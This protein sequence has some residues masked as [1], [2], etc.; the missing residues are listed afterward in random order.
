MAQDLK[1]VSI[2][3][4]TNKI[5]QVERNEKCD[6]EYNRVFYSKS[7]NSSRFQILVAENWYEND[8]DF[9]IVYGKD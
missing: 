5:G 6:S 8:C 1:V 3:K 7:D 9:Q 4:N 2:L